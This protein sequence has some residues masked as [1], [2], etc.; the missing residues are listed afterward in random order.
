MQFLYV[1]H[2]LIKWQKWVYKRSMWA[3]RRETV[4]VS[5]L[6][7]LLSFKITLCPNHRSPS[8]P[9]SQ[10][11]PYKSLPHC[12]SPSLQR[13]GA[14]PQGGT[15]HPGTSSLSRSRHILSHWA[16]PD[17]LSRRKGDAVSWNRHWA[18][19]T[20]VMESTGRPH[21]TLTANMSRDLFYFLCLFFPS[22][23]GSTAM[24]V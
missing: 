5:F 6:F 8:F 17:S 20:L 23:L 12:P 3:W 14:P 2:S 1:N 22:L 19:A 7:S 10:S 9:S 16:Q 4:S 24:Y 21:C 15:T 13:K 18:R 11:Y